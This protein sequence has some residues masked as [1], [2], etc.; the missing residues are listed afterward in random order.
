MMPP[1]PTQVQF[2]PIEG[3]A[4]LRVRISGDL[5]EHSDF[6]SVLA[7]TE[8]FLRL[9]LSG[10]SRINSCGVREWM[11][12]IDALRASDRAF[13]LEACA[14]SFVTQM[15]MISNFAGTARVLSFYGPYLC[16]ACDEER[17]ELFV[18]TD[19]E[20]VELPATKPCSVCR[21]EMEFDDIPK[22]Y[23]SFLAT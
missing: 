1:R 14:V 20:A 4:K 21:A 6:S 3:E 10:I 2:E 8:S 5:T 13:E 11:R 16:T 9:N 7:R 22:L 23:L 18:I 19:G 15:N 17:H 12:L